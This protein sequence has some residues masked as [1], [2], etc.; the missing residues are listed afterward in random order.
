MK[1]RLE[2]FINFLLVFDTQTSVQPARQAFPDSTGI[3]AALCNDGITACFPG[4][5]RLFGIGIEKFV[6]TYSV[7][8]YVSFSI[9]SACGALLCS[10]F[11]YAGMDTNRRNQ[12]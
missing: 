8:L 1:S 12:W 5:R 4:P 6:Y 7:I 9:E 11:G 10:A 2:I 3:A